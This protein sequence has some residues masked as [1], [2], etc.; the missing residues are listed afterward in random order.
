[1]FSFQNTFRQIN[2]LLWQKHMAALVSTSLKRQM[3]TT[4]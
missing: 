2:L 4:R 1:M 3:T